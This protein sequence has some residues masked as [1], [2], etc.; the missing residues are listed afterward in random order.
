M[1]RPLALKSAA[2]QLRRIVKHVLNIVLVWA[3]FVAPARAQQPQPASFAG[4][5]GQPVSSIQ[6]AAGPKVDT[7]SLR[8]LISIQASKP[9]SAEALRMSVASLQQTHLFTQVQ[10][11]FE[12]D[13]NGLRII[14]ILQPADYVGMISFPGAGTRFAYTALIQAVNIPEQSP[15]VPDLL[16][17]GQ[18]NLQKYFRAQGYF[19]AEVTVQIQR[20]EPHR[21]VNLVF[22][23]A[24]KRQAKIRS[25]RSRLEARQG[26]AHQEDPARVH[27]QA[28]SAMQMQSRVYE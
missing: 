20:D 27:R 1:K 7:D 22:H 14:F 3:L 10:V 11:S 8:K 17:Q 21:I 25:V 13:Q 26:A 24:P 23:C 18:Q 9:F 16:A 2:P 12:P 5:E 6:I 28:Q 19:Q 15:F 4:F